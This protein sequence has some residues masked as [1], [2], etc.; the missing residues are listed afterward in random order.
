MAAAVRPAAVVLA[1]SRTRVVPAAVA[2]ASATVEAPDPEDAPITART[3]DAGVHVALG[4]VLGWRR[5]K[6]P[7]CT[8]W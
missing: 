2:S 6:V 3:G 1:V 7:A 8:A 5:R 4:G